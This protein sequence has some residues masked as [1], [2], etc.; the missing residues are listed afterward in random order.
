MAG[1]TRCSARQHRR[2]RGAVR[3]EPVWA[4]G[5]LGRSLPVP[6]GGRRAMP[7]VRDAAGQDPHREHRKLH[8][9]RV[10][11]LR[12]Q[13]TGRQGVAT[14]GMM[15]SGYRRTVVL[16]GCAE[17]SE[18]PRVPGSSYRV[19]PGS[20]DR[21]AKPIWPLPRLCPVQFSPIDWSPQVLGPAKNCLT[22]VPVVV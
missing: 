17:E 22:R 3:A 12:A 14:A 15:V 21:S 20:S 6:L 8:L 9:S 11:A 5:W 19:V 16:M 10:P 7:G 4:E 18:S 2:R 1:A 13:V